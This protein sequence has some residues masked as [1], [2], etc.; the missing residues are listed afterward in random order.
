MQ[1]NPAGFNHPERVALY[2]SNL[3]RDVN[4]MW[5]DDAT[6]CCHTMFPIFTLGCIYTF[7]VFTAAQKKR[8][9]FHIYLLKYIEKHTFLTL[10]LNIL[11][12][13]TENINT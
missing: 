11:N 3:E 2:A 6:I 5:T 7:P 13:F 9:C 12:I 1:Q 10:T 8:V 4:D